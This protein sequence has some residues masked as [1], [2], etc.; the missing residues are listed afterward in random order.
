LLEGLAQGG[1]IVAELVEIP[2]WVVLRPELVGEAIC[3]VLKSG[4]ARVPIDGFGHKCAQIM[5]FAQ[6]PTAAEE[7]SLEEPLSCLLE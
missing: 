2:T 3:E 4:E 6:F 7:I 5:D 1:V